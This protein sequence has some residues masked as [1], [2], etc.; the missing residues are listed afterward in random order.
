MICTLFKKR[1]LPHLHSQQASVRNSAAWWWWKTRSGPRA[2]RTR[3][4]A[5][6]PPPP[7]RDL[8]LQ[9][10]GTETPRCCACR[11]ER[12]K[13]P[14]IPAPWGTRCHCIL[15]TRR[16]MWRNSR[17]ITI[18]GWPSAAWW[19]FRK[20]WNNK[21]KA[22]YFPAPTYF[23]GWRGNPYLRGQPIPSEQLWRC[24]LKGHFFPETSL[25][26][27]QAHQMMVCFKATKRMFG[28]LKENPWICFPPPFFFNC[29]LL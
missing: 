3:R 26:K 24:L 13:C 29:K 28:K 27:E 21:R 10:K 4:Q 11:S 16:M 15:H 22:P 1:I 9:S 2:A 5:P 8:G 17:K 18:C 23:G 12:A 20:T 25:Q 14:H 19:L 6:R 7:A